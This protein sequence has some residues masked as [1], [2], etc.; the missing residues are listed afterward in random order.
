MILQTAQTRTAPVH[1]EWAQRAT[2]QHI[3]FGGTFL[4]LTWTTGGYETSVSRRQD[5]GSWRDN[6][7]I[8]SSLLCCVLFYVTLYIGFYYLCSFFIF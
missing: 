2:Q 4:G 6:S 1:M 8:M 7:A 5:Q 3:I